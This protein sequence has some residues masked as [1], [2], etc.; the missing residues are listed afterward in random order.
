VLD[1]G[2]DTDTLSY[3]SLSGGVSV[4]LQGATASTV[5]GG[6]A[7]VISNFENLIGSNFADSLRG[8]DLQA[9]SIDGGT[10][11]DTVD[12][13][14]GNFADTLAGGAGTNTL[15]YASHTAAG[16][17]VAVTLNTTGAGTVSGACG[18]DVISNFTNAIGSAG[19][20][21]LSGD[22]YSNTISGGAGD[23]LIDGGNDL[24]ADV[25]DGAGGNDTLTFANIVNV[26]SFGVNLTLN[27]AAG[28]TVQAVGGNAASGAGA[29]AVVNFENVIGSQYAD[30]LGGDANANSLVGGNGND[31]LDGGNDALAD[32]LDGGNGTDTLS[33]AFLAN[34]NAWGVDVT[35][36]GGTPATVQAVAG[37]AA[38]GSGADVVVNF[39]NV[40][41]SQYDDHLTGDGGANSLYGGAGD[42]VVEGGLGND[43]LDGGAHAN[44]DTLSYQQFG[45]AYGSAAGNVGVTA[46]LAWNGDATAHD[47]TG[48]GAG[49]G[50]V[51]A[52]LDQ[53]ANFQKLIGSGFNDSLAG[54]AFA[55]TLDGGAGDDTLDGGAGADSLLG[56]VGNDVIGGGSDAV[57][58]TLDGGTGTNTLSFASLSTGSGV[59][60][61]LNGATQ[62]AISGGAGADLISNFAN[63]VGS[64]FADS[65]TGDVNA[66]SIGGGVGDDTI[67]GGNDALVDTLDGGLGANTL[68][69]ASL[70]TGS[71]V[72]VTL[73]G[74]TQVAI[75]GGA[76]ADLISN[77]A[78][79]VGSQYADNLTGDG[80]A[81]TIEGGAG[82]DVLSG[83]AGSDTVSFA[84][85]G[86]AVAVN[87]NAGAVAAVAGYYAGVAGAT[88]TGSAT[89]TDALSA[90][91]N[92]LGGAGNDSLFG[93]N[94]SNSI[95]GGAG[96][97]WID[98]GSGNVSDTLDGGLG[99]NTVSYILAGNAVTVSL[100]LLGSAQNTGTYGG[101]DTLYNFQNLVGSAGGDTL[102]GASGASRASN[103][104]FGY[105]GNDV[106]YAGSGN[107]N[108][109][110]DGGT[111]TDT[112]NYQG[113]VGPIVLSY[114]GSTATGTASGAN[115]GT[116]TLTTMEYFIG[117]AAA[118]TFT[119]TGNA[120]G[121]YLSYS[122]LSV[123]VALDLADS[124]AATA[125]GG[126]GADVV[127]GF[128]NLIGSGGNDVL[129]GTSGAN[130]IYGGAGDDNIFGDAGNDNIFGEAGNDTLNG[131]LGT[132]W[133]NYS[134]AGS[135][136]TVSLAI[137]TAQN[138]GGAGTDVLTNFEYLYGS[139]YADVLT[140]DAG[141][142]SIDG[143]N[144]N[145][146]LEGGLGNDTLQ[147][148]GNTDT[149]SY[150]NLG[151]T[152]GAAGTGVTVSLAI[153]TAQNTGAAGTDT[154]QNIENLTG[155]GYNDTLTDSGAN[156]TVNVIDG[157]AG[158]DV[159]YSG[160]AAAGGGADSLI[161]GTGNDVFYVYAGAPYAR[162]YGDVVQAN[163]NVSSDFDGVVVRGLGTSAT[164]ASLTGNAAGAD[165]SK[166][167]NVEVID[168]HGDGV[169]TTI[170][171]TAAALTSDVHFITGS[172]SG[173]DLYII[174]D[175]GDT[176]TPSGG[177]GT[178][179][180]AAP[181][182][183]STTFNGVTYTSDTVYT[184]SAGNEHLH[185]L[186]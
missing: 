53:I 151:V 162:I 170:T 24:V 88:A 58:D 182:T 22:G 164:L 155:S 44:G 95:V 81:N 129:S 93:D 133:V 175:A 106:I 57:A 125:S 113:T 181:A 118:D 109:A 111:G 29:D 80:N 48:V 82:N 59:T 160:T 142:N 127:T 91:E 167:F 104:I 8:D 120:I 105:N 124:G 178:W 90:F 92:I 121:M 117:T 71:G 89:G 45:V 94:T 134:T 157:G 98:G 174:H 84:S 110:F 7:D 131:G 5:T 28:A 12:G 183:V 150:A 126:G 166:L 30:Y 137:A 2:A 76:G 72:T 145:D 54:D 42:D 119:A 25:L 171:D 55:N 69:F 32:T 100:N 35:L 99:T 146:T 33:F 115:I 83:G 65:L 139:A 186:S 75:G 10:G 165:T 14:D 184:N 21:T 154:L 6:G 143:A 36:N 168:I 3:A 159:F 87:L 180:A 49:G 116:D 16:A 144:G 73:N 23:D 13:G 74:A 77:F 128:V 17:G 135:A 97:D 62:V 51:G 132:D 39:E 37:N 19:D 152:Y 86:A 138:T 41:G 78:N 50:Y 9:N 20:D 122:N 172:V 173:G 60:V 40:F 148:N 96:N 163:N 169:N 130:V 107:V 112:I 156:T 15:S 108:D 179:S 147:G 101:T 64:Q 27:G 56:G 123:G 47:T 140:G 11:N 136:V 61:T 70:A 31:T 18:A 153:G 149:A 114:N 66:N 102:S 85:A 4:H 161:G 43:T 141:N 67:D 185:W 46:S 52:G 1:G 26:A 79:I 176:L 38:S 158:N 177:W 34:A 103:S 68:S 63:I